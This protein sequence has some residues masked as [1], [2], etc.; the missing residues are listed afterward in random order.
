M[1]YTSLRNQRSPLRLLR[2]SKEICSDHYR[3]LD[4][5]DEY[6]HPDA[7]KK[8]GFANRDKADV[9]KLRSAGKEVLK[10]VGSKL[11]KAIMGGGFDLFNI[12]FPIKCMGDWSMVNAIGTMACTA[13]YYMTASALRVDPVERMKFLITGQI[14]YQFPCHKFA[15]PVSHTILFIAQPNPRRDLLWRAG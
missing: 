11:V 14:S 6:R 5:D 13:P 4:Y 10:Q 8:G 3:P 1:T 9:S 7:A 2:F 12:S 15:K